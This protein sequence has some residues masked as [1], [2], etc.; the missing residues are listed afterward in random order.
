MRKPFMSCFGVEW[1]IPLNFNFFSPGSSL[2]FSFD[3][4]GIKERIMHF[5][6]KF[7]FLF[8]IFAELGSTA[9]HSEENVFYNDN[10]ILSCFYSLCASRGIGFCSCG[11]GKKKAKA[12]RWRISIHP[13]RIIF[14]FCVIIT[15]IFF[16]PSFF[17][18]NRL[19]LLGKE[20]PEG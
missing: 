14:I 1:M 8:N 2:L 17:S 10:P 9:R 15:I 18:E 20:R 6:W 16:S 13:H 4:L 5:K 19:C 3:S 7:L 11:G 12:I